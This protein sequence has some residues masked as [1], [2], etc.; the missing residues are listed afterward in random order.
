MNLGRP[1]PDPTKTAS[2]PFSNSSSIVKVLPITTLVS[3]STPNC[4][5]VSTSLATIDLG[6]L[7]SGIPYTSTPP[8]V[9]SASY[10][11]TS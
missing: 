6:N 4:F 2:K 7:N 5:K 11:V 9:C 8:A 1:A 3:T 10:I